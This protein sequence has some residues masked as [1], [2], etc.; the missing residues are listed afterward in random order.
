MFEIKIKP[1][2]SRNPGFI[3]KLYIID[4]TFDLVKID[5]QLNDAANRGGILDTIN[6][7]QQMLPFNDSLYLPVDFRAIAE[8][9]Y[10]GLVRFGFEMNTILYNYKINTFIDDDIFD[11]AV[12]KVL[13]TADDKDT[14]YWKNIQSIPNTTKENLA[15][16]KINSLNS[17][18]I[19][20]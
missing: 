18:P 20:D 7:Y 4:K 15:Y 1:L 3:G 13:P 2:D 19:N 14:N 16:K 11:K 12:I 10:L 5:F 17:I 9:N 8:I 6:F